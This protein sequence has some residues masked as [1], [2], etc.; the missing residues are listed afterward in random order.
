MLAIMGVVVLVCVI[1]YINLLAKEKRTER[2]YRAATLAEENS[3]KLAWQYTQMISDLKKQAE[4]QALCDEG[5]EEV[6]VHYIAPNV[7]HD[8]TGE[9]KAKA[10]IKSKLVGKLSKSLKMSENT[11]DDGRKSYAIHVKVRK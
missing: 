2:Q 11:L 4:Q 6:T 3:K 10:A 1:I 5:W 9:K 8:N 7:S